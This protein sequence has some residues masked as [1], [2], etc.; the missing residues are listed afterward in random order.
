MRITQDG[1]QPTVSFIEDVPGGDMRL[2]TP[3]GVL[4]ASQTGEVGEPFYLKDGRE[5]F[6]P[7]WVDW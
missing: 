3:D 1:N 2:E 5:V 4:L 7:A 6:Y